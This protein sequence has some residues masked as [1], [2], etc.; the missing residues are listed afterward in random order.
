MLGFLTVPSILLD[1][2]WRKSGQVFAYAE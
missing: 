1:F 2:A